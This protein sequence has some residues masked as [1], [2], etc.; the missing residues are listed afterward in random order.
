MGFRNGSYATVWSVESKSPTVTRARI[1]ISR[2]NKNTGEY[3]QDFSDFVSFIGTATATNALK[4]KEK[5]RI[6][7]GESDVRTYYDKEKNRTYYNFNI[8][9]F[10]DVTRGHDGAAASPQPVID[11]VD[12]GEVDDEDLPF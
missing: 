12:N 4:L 9:G 1:S 5:D 3:E 2:K 11:A 7:I 8:Y 10:E 6:R